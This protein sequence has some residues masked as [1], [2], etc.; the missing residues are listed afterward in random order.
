MSTDWACFPPDCLAVRN[1][2]VLNGDN[3]VTSFAW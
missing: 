1:Y 3:T 2:C